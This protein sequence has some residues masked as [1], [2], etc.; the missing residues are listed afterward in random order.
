MTAVLTEQAAQRTM[1]RSADLAWHEQA[2]CTTTDPEIFFP[3]DGGKAEPARRLCRACPV[4]EECLL[5]AVSAPVYEFG[6]WGGFTDHDI[7]A[8]ARRY[9]A[10]ASLA[11]I[12]ADD[13]AAYYAKQDRRAES[14]ETKRRNERDLRQAKIAAA[15]NRS[16]RKA[17]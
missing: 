9:R 7:R 10:G 1:P 15:T 6:V 16:P 4:R 11:G 13:D 8:I 14:L 12:I 2:R 3:E 17:A 5:S